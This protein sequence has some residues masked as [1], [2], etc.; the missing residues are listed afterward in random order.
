MFDEKTDIKPSKVK[1]MLRTLYQEALYNY[2]DDYKINAYTEQINHD[3]YLQTKVTYTMKLHCDNPK[4]ITIPT[5][6]IMKQIENYN[7]HRNEKAKIKNIKKTIIQVNKLVDK[8]IKKEVLPVSLTQFEVFYKRKN[9]LTDNVRPLVDIHPTVNIMFRC[10]LELL[11]EDCS[12]K[13]KDKSLEIKHT[14]LQK[15]LENT[16]KYLIF[17]LD[18]KK[19][20]DSIS[21]NAI[22]DILFQFKLSKYNFL[23]D[24]LDQCEYV[25]DKDVVYKKEFGIPQGLPISTF[26][27]ELVVLSITKKYRKYFTFLRY[28]DDICLIVKDWV[29]YEQKLEEMLADFQLVGLFLNHEK[30]CYMTHNY[31][32]SHST[33]KI[34]DIKHPE[35]YLGK[36]IV[37][38]DLLDGVKHINFDMLIIDTI[39]IM[40]KSPSMIHLMQRSF[41]WRFRWYLTIYNTND[42][43]RETVWR[44]LQAKYMYAISNIQKEVPEFIININYKQLML[45]V[46]LKKPVLTYQEYT[47][48]TIK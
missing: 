34:I 13:F 23:L 18:F 1:K 24:Y 26:L 31:L 40:K 39:D 5:K 4:S 9:R 41:Q 15:Y 38:R 42:T 16:N 10:V 32:Y 27:F 44:K 46:K 21:R 33:F 25:Y 48:N 37:S 22:K 47:Y 43:S 30:T 6:I 17:F 11:K 14:F 45:Q 3:K 36:Y 12:I 8:L 35:K 20:F 7:S 29:Q 28:V 2:K 19:A